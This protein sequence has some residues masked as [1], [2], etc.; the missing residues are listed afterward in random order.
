LDLP[1]FAA[2]A[3]LAA[4]ADAATRNFTV[5]G[6]DRVRVDGPYRVK[7]TTGVAPFARAEGSVAG[8]DAL[9]LEVQGRT[10]IIRR[11]APVKSN[12]AQPLG[13]VAIAVGTHELGAAW[14]NGSGGIAINR[15]KGQKFELGVSG[16][17]AVEV[18][19]LSV[20]RLGVSILGSASVA[21]AGAVE[22]ASFSLSGPSSLDA[23]GLTTKA[24][25]IDADGSSTIK[26]T[27]TGTA[28]V[29]GNGL[30]TIEL[31][32]GPACTI[33]PSSSA[34]VSGCR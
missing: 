22:T 26:L 27:A 10:L 12:A 30:A 5:T 7:L 3:L 14:V 31:A 29:D 16:S 21:L 2:L 32:G 1:A 11:K 25:T 18:G 20:D 8:L 6:F 28:K 19:K 23:A 17:G 4:P 34:D 15:V 24:A 9:S 13:P 33:R